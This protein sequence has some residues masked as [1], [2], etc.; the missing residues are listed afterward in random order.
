MNYYILEL[1]LCATFVHLAGQTMPGDMRDRMCACQQ[2][3]KIPSTSEK[4]PVPKSL[5]TVQS[6]MPN[7][8]LV[9]ANAILVTVTFVFIT[10]LYPFASAEKVSRVNY[11]SCI[12]FSGHGVG[13]GVGAVVISK[14]FNKG[15]S[16]HNHAH[17]LGV[18]QLKPRPY[19]QRWKHDNLV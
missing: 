14:N 5:S 18:A 8:S 1:T 12:I 4:L 13:V 15:G 7:R 16:T 19:F 11:R 10:L 3:C 9:V 2:I 6:R 17:S